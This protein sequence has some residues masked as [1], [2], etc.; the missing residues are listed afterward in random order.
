MGSAKHEK[1]FVDFESAYEQNVVGL[2]GIIYFGVGLLLLI[3]ITF[4]LMWALHNVLE[5]DAIENKSSTHPM[6]HAMKDKERLP[7]EP[8][9]QA[10]PGFGVDSPDGRAI[11]ELKEPQAEYRE[12]KK[13]WD[14]ALKD[15]QK[16]EKTGTVVSMPIERAKQ[17]L[18]TKGLKAKSGPEA[19]AILHDS[20]LR[21]GDANSGR[22][23]NVR[24]R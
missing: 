4:A 3:I 7:P 11:L 9:L 19:E 21:L 10:A 15:G 1:S 14:K 23:P 5:E 12:L 24:R 13:Q 17:L 16:D 6:Q 20:V 18:L 22:A 8:R 2:K